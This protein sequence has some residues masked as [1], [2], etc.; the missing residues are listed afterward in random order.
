MNDTTLEIVASALRDNGMQV[1]CV[2]RKEEVVP[3]VRSLLKQGDAVGVG[4]SVTLFETGV[5]DL[6]K[7]GDYRFLDRYAEGLSAADITAVM[8]DSMTADVYL[9]SANAVTQ[10]GELY[11][12]DGRGNRVAALTFG[13]RS[14]I[15]VV[16]N[17]KIVR[18]IPE[19]VRR[20]KTVA[21]PR[22]AKRL[23]CQTY[24][25][26]YGVCKAVDSDRYTDGC[27]SPDRI[28]SQY[29]ITARQRVRD[30]IHVILVDEPLG[31]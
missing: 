9:C 10:N 29:V 23:G 12:V 1:T 8:N 31:F 30:R 28:C 24:C 2:S 7:S 14:V 26:V 3:L 21:A 27:A 22:N 11:N 6:L 17:N 4:G 18:D 15:V 19:A 5:I 16:G 20:V 13:P 25:A